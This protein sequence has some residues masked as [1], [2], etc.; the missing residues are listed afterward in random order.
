MSKSG[1]LKAA[2]GAILML[3]I[4]ASLSG[5][6]APA[7]QQGPQPQGPQ[8]PPAFPDFNTTI[9]GLQP[10]PRLITLY[11]ANPPDPQRDS[12]K[13]LA[14]IPRALLNPDLLLASTISRG[15][16]AGFNWTDCLI[17]FEMLDKKVIIS[18]PDTQYV[19]NP[20]TTA[21]E[22]VGR[23]HTSGFLAAMQIVTM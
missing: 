23:T 1:I 13:L 4:S 17:R 8:A 19:R 7:P 11:S 22:L 18:I 15:A 14:Q 21:G 20:N 10:S 5:Q 6:T 2:I 9:K 3:G 16:D 12:P